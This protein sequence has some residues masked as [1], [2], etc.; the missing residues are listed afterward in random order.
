MRDQ[1]GDAFAESVLSLVR[2]AYPLA[3]TT[4]AVLLAKRIWS[5]I[6]RQSTQ[7]RRALEAF[8]PTVKSQSDPLEFQGSLFDDSGSVTV[9]GDPSH[10]Q[11]GFA[12][13]HKVSRCL[14]GLLE[15]D[16]WE[17]VNAGVSNFRQIL[18]N[19]SFSNFRQILQNSSFTNTD[20]SVG[21]MNPH[22][23]SQDQYRCLDEKVAEAQRAAFRNPSKF[24]V[25]Q[26]R[27]VGG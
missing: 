22:F 13:L 1:F 27:R 21:D 15:S 17:C 26:Y 20:E 10:H 5:L 3:N 24:I 19:S 6:K 12:E 23:A 7:A 16:G 25:H 14:K 4:A 18:Q 8:E 2:S 11:P 9:L